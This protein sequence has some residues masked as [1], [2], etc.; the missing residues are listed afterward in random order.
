MIGNPCSPSRCNLHVAH[1]E[2]PSSQPRRFAQAGRPDLP[3]HLSREQLY[4]WMAALSARCLG[5][6]G[7]RLSEPAHFSAP[8][9]RL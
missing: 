6:S 7:D 5:A 1:L 9:K 2:R 8:A 4:H 3:S